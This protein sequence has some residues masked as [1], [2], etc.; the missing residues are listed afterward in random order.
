[1][2]LQRGEAVDP[3]TPWRSVAVMGS[4]PGSCCVCRHLLQIFFSSTTNLFLMLNYT[5]KSLNYSKCALCAA[6]SAASAAWTLTWDSKSEFGTGPCIVRAVLLRIYY[7]KSKRLLP[8]Y[9]ETGDIT[10]IFSGVRICLEFSASGSELIQVE[11]G[12]FP[13]C[14]W[15]MNVGDFCSPIPFRMVMA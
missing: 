3:R 6:V 8:S 9:L 10:S 5:W 7:L 2:E 1:V 11:C 14:S 15:K 4:K 12:V 13:E